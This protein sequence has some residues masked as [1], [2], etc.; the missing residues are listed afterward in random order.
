MESTMNWGAIV[1]ATLVP[2]VIGAIW[3]NPR[4]MGNFWLRANNT[5]ADNMRGANMALV[6]IGATVLAFLLAMFMHQNVTGAG[7][8][9]ARYITFQ[10]GM[11]H[12]TAVTIMLAIPFFGTT[13]LFERR[14]WNWFL[15]HIGYW[16]IS[17]MVMG[18]ILSLWR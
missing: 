9:D 17:L 7:Q 16:W 3:Y 1:A 15:V 10:H 5:T 11:V 18:G 14:G 4:V 2:L 8:E 13:A 6:Y 12:G